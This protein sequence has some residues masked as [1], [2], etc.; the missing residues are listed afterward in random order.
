MSDQ[1]N[2]DVDALLGG[3]APRVGEVGSGRRAQ[4]AIDLAAGMAAV[5]TPA[6]IDAATLAAYL[7]Q[8]LAEEDKQNLL[9]QLASSPPLRSDV[10]SAAALLEAVESAPRLPSEALRQRALA[11][12]EGS[13][14]RARQT[15]T[16]WWRMSWIAKPGARMS[17]G[18]ACALTVAVVVFHS[19][20]PIHPS[21]EPVTAPPATGT[22]PR[23]IVSELA[24]PPPS[25]SA[26]STL[27]PPSLRPPGASAVGQW[28]AIAVSPSTH[29]YGTAHKSSSEE[30][31]GAALKA[32][33]KTGATDCAL[34]VTGEGQCLV[35]GA[36]PAG[37]LIS[38][39]DR[40]FMTAQR[41]LFALCQ[42][43]PGAAGCR[44]LTFA[45]ANYFGSPL[46]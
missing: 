46:Q 17:V 25:S 37:M 24:S 21:S 38:A 2:S 27:A 14:A 34:Q 18:V 35:V 41:K 19:N 13:G 22:A 32:C 39:Q 7:D 23:A 45:C 16:P 3:P 9:S 1:L 20:D 36:T 8:G 43:T 33:S 29:R 26:K 44:L 5:S 42:T 11:L 4:L 40:D 10:D 12:L 28:A 30:A 15:K 6:T 31:N